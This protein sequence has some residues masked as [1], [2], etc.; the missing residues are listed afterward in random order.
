[1]RRGQSLTQFKNTSC[2]FHETGASSE[3][4][5][6]TR[7]YWEVTGGSQHQQERRSFAPGQEGDGSRGWD[8]EPCDTFSMTSERSTSAAGRHR[9]ACHLAV[10]LSAGL[11]RRVWPGHCRDTETC[12][13]R[14]GSLQ[15]DWSTDLADVV[16]T[17]PKGLSR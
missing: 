13:S 7:V 11:V 2:A 12:P 3:V 5:S 17:A 14:M 16:V 8:W 1:M 10:P 6:R 9:R 4:V 15:P